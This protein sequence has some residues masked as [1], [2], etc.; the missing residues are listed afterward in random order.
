[1]TPRKRQ[2]QDRPVQLNVTLQ[3]DVYNKLTALLTAEGTG[4]TNVNLVAELI[5][6]EYEKN[7][8]S[9]LEQ[10]LAARQHDIEVALGLSAQLDAIC[11]EPPV[12]VPGQ[13]F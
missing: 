3:P 5:K 13:K 2:E 9:I 10:T 8:I 4:A 1:M 7:K 6:S 12:Y 11:S